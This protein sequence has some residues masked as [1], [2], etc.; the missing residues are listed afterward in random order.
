M[1]NGS[2][3]KNS[4]GRRER[5]K[6]SSQTRGREPL[7]SFQTDSVIELDTANQRSI[8]SASDRVTSLSRNVTRSVTHFQ[9]LSAPPRPKF[10]AFRHWRN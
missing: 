8:V 2:I 1:S 3:G 9:A 6:S 10:P 7:G 4:L 5:E